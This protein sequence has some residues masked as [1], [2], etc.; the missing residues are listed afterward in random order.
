MIRLFAGIE[1]PDHIKDQLYALRG[2]VPNAVWTERDNLHIT[3]RFIGNIDEHEAEYL[4]DG[5]SQIQAPAFDLEMAQVGFL[6]TAR[7]CGIYGQ[8]SAISERW[9]FCTISWKASPSGTAWDPISINAF[10]RIALWQSYAARR[11]KTSKNSSNTITCFVRTR[12][13]LIISRCFPAIPAR[14]GTVPTIAWKLNT[15]CSAITAETK[16]F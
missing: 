6:P 1:L 4:H 9:T 7:K 15:L 5:F 13:P 2:G 8:G 12:F 10:T 16:T 11:R 3:L 14:T